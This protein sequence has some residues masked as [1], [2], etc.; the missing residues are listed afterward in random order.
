MDIWDE[1]KRRADLE[2]H[3]VDFRL[4][5]KLDWA[6]AW[7]FEDRRRDYGERRLI[8]LVPLG[9]RLH[10]VVYTQRNGAR[11]IISA[12]KANRREVEAYEDAIDPARL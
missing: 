2:K 5:A 10:A 8:A 3:G 12:R 7:V 4:L 11:R 6:R 1:T 9:R